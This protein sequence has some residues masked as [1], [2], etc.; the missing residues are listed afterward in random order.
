MQEKHNSVINHMSFT[1][2]LSNKATRHHL[3]TTKGHTKKPSVNIIGN[4]NCNAIKVEMS[5]RAAEKAYEEERNAM[6]DAFEMRFSEMSD[7]E[8]DAEFPDMKDEPIA[9]T[10]PSEAHEFLAKDFGRDE[11][12]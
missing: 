2:C 5:T 7:D 8:F 10:L 6:W 4:K 3:N 9:D 12:K 1:H 11:L